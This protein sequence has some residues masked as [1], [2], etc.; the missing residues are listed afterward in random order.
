M[1]R[2]GGF[3]HAKWDVV[4]IWI[5]VRKILTL[6]LFLGIFFSWTNG[7]EYISHYCHS[8]DF[9]KQNGCV[10]S[11]L[12]TCYSAF[13]HS[14]SSFSINYWWAVWGIVVASYGVEADTV[15]LVT[16]PD[17]LNVVPTPWLGA[18]AA[19]SMSWEIEASMNS[20]FFS[21]WGCPELCFH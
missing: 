21:S 13:R 3:R 12:F 8:T 17:P 1:Q 16:F 10:F 20:A 15:V 2:A 11:L 6:L 9:I 7:K 18:E 14:L 19:I 4:Y 5:R